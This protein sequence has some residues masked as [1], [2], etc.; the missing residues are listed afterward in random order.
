MPDSQKQSDTPPETIGDMSMAEICGTVSG[1]PDRSMVWC[2]LVALNLASRG[3][4]NLGNLQHLMVI[5][6]CESSGRP[7]AKNPTSSARG[8]LQHITP[9]RDA[10]A[11]KYLGR[12]VPDWNDPGDNVAV[13]VALY[14]DPNGGGPSHWPNCGRR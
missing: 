7:D 1:V 13:G 2:P 3:G 12:P 8:L 10:R 4:L 6:D 14:L 11:L 5:L 9:F